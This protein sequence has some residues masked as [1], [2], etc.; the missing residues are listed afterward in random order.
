MFN[1]L[2]KIR[3]TLYLDPRGNK[4]DLY[5]RKILQK[6]A[7]D[8]AKLD[9]DANDGMDRFHA[10][11]IHKQIYMSGLF[12]H[13]LSPT[14]SK[15]LSNLVIEGEVNSQNLL[16]CLTVGGIEGANGI[17][18]TI[19]G[20]DGGDNKQSVDLALINDSIEQLKQSV[21]SAPSGK[22]GGA[23]LNIEVKSD[24]KEILDLVK[25]NKGENTSNGATDVIN[26]LTLQ[27]E[28]QSKLIEK[29]LQGQIP[30]NT[31]QSTVQAKNLTESQPP[32]S[33]ELNAEVAERMS[34]VKKVKGKGAF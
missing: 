30:V 18:G 33:S 21:E 16:K 27:I 23:G 28:K 22:A 17:E 7:S 29:L 20:G 9:S 25:S 2:D 5:T 10:V 24:I 8:L 34:K 14:A 32:K 6:W 3:F 11:S 15:Q 12:L 13:L 19:V 1:Q 31:S 26:G 4:A